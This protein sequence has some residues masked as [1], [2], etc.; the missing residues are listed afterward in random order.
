MP[1]AQ[2]VCYSGPEQL[3]LRTIEVPE[4]G[5]EDVLLRVAACGVCGSD[6]HQFHGRWSQPEGVSGHEISA[7]VERVGSNVTEL[8]QNDKVILEPIVRCGR[9]R[10]CQTGRYQHC[11]SGSF[12]SEASD[13]GFAQLMRV[14][15]YCCYK[16]GADVD[17]PLG[18]FGEPL[19]V[20][21]HAVRLAR[22]NGEDTVL[23]IGAGTI[24]LMTV[25]AAK[26]MGAGRII[27]T[28][29]YDHQGDAA[30]ALGADEV[31]P[32]GDG[33]NE[34]VAEICG[35]GPDFVIE[36]VGTVGGATEQALQ[37]ARP[38]G[39]VVL[40]GGITGPCEINL[41][42]IIGKELTIL[43]SPCY[44]QIGLRGDFEIAAELLS[45][46]AVDVAPL[47]TARYP[48]EQ[49]QEAFIAADDKSTGAIKVLI[50]PNG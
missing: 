12:I 27:A 49:I 25:A 7:V 3:E 30:R 46:G 2:G 41:A 20:G 13:G 26:A 24:G 39:T 11:E 32:V 44:G 28:A 47:V 45:T 16:L 9:C 34:R 29:K 33:L 40:V 38:L 18:A 36:T 19:A 23:V 1:T 14:P 6:L 17:L 50:L 43:G 42:P 37:L 8:Q 15:S 4:P 22:P 10:Y 48:L 5:P 35:D 21:L 31:L